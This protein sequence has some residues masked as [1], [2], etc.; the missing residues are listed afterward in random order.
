LLLEE[1][2]L[3]STVLNLVTVASLGSSYT[4]LHFDT[5]GCFFFVLTLAS[6]DSCSGQKL[7]GSRASSEM[8]LLSSACPISSGPVAS[9]E[10]C[11][12]SKAKDQVQRKETSVC[13][14][15]T[16]KLIKQIPPISYQFILFAGSM[17]SHLLKT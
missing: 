2:F 13:G 6:F 12:A 15:K 3:E 5:A 7:G 16:T 11:K 8:V 1:S 9:L 17:V 14:Q 4:D 10:A